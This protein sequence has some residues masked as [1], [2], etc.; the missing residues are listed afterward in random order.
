MSGKIGDLLKVANWKSRSWTPSR[1]AV[2]T[3]L[4]EQPERQKAFEEW[5]GKEPEGRYPEHI[6]AEWQ[7]EAEKAGNRR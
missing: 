5:A 1:C 6:S 4:K 3:A 7:A 2:W